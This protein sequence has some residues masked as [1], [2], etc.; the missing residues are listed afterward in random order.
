MEPRERS[1]RLAFSLFLSPPPVCISPEALFRKCL[2]ICLKSH[3]FWAACQIAF[4][5]I[6]LPFF[7]FSCVEFHNGC[8]EGKR[9]Q[10]PITPLSSR[11]HKVAKAN[12][13][14]EFVKTSA[15][16]SQLSKPAV[17]AGF[18]GFGRVYTCGR[19][20]VRASVC[21]CAACVCSLPQCL[22]FIWLLSYCQM[23]SEAG[24]GG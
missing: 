20:C 18:W 1:H 23:D 17:L 2:G 6:A 19:V 8:K 3:T 16:V 5:L 10:K 14:N 11:A 24:K 7:V 12:L 13:R 4:S 9:A 21:A 15:M 22:L